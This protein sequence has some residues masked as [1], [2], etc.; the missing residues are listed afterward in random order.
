[1]VFS[2][3]NKPKSAPAPARERVAKPKVVPTVHVGGISTVAKRAP[4]EEVFF[5]QP[6]T[7]DAVKKLRRQ[8]T[9]SDLR[10]KDE[11]LQWMSQLPRE[12]RPMKTCQAYPHVV[13]HLA[14]WWPIPEGLTDYFDDLLESKR[15]GRQGFPEPVRKELEVLQT[16]AR[17]K[18]LLIQ[19]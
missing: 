15:K 4:V 12:V 3:F 6:G 5:K 7:S 10:L 1:M 9:A 17:L 16:Y 2:F 11:A 13:N 19:R 8:P 18:K 14:G